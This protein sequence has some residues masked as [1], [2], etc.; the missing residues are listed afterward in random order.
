MN[1]SITYCTINMFLNLSLKK[2][3][4]TKIIAEIDGH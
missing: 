4:V 1:R 3:L 2:Q